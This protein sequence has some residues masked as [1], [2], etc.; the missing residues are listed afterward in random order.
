MKLNLNSDEAQ[1]IVDELRNSVA[2]RKQAQPEYA[3]KL[4]GIADKILKASHTGKP[5]YRKTK[6]F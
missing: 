4:Q 1:I 6:H 3:L 2:A 5:Q